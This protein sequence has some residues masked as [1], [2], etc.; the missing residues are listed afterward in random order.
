MPANRGCR[1]RTGAGNAFGQSAMVATQALPGQ[2]HD[3]ARRTTLAAFD[4]AAGGA[5]ERRR[6]AAAIEEDERLLPTR[7]ALRERFEERRDNALLGR[8]HPR[9]DQAY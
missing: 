2:M 8:M 3:H 7:K 1:I 5:G 9:V 6:I 4:P